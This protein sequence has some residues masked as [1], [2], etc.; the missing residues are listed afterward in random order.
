MDM[1]A[2]E[3]RAF[4]EEGDGESTGWI[5]RATVRTCAGLIDDGSNGGQSDACGRVRWWFGDVMSANQVPTD[6]GSKR[7]VTSNRKR[8]IKSCPRHIHL[9]QRHN[10]GTL[11]TRIQQ[12]P[13]HEPEDRYTTD[14]R[15]HGRRCT[16]FTHLR[17]PHIEIP[18]GLGRLL[19]VTGRL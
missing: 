3:E 4:G 1:T 11:S 19:R 13:E 9:H 6:L 2:A 14:S 16:S 5:G 7:R 8:L 18:G 17:S 12:P 10:L 15:N